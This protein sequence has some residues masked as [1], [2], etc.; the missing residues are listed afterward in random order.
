MGDRRRSWTWAALLVA[1]LASGC[2][3][4][5]AEA[6]ARLEQIKLEGR[7]FDAQLDAVE[8]RLLG[9]QTRVSIWQELGQRHQ[10]VSALACANV[11]KHTD[12]M[13]VLRDKQAEKGRHRRSEAAREVLPTGAGVGGPLSVVPVQ[14]DPAEN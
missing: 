3:E 2:F 11:V 12:E 8:D 6:K 1:P 4:P 9:N 14:A 13:V 10:E 5:S 7:S